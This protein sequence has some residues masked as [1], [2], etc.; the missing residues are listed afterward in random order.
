MKG[1]TGIIVALLLGLL[2]AS[3]NWVYLDN[4]TRQVKTV[5]F[6]GVRN[7]AKIR[8]GDTLQESFLEEVRIPEM[9]VGNLKTFVYLWQELETVKGIRAIRAYQGAE[10]LRR[11][12]YV[13]PPPELKLGKGQLL[14]WVPVDGRAF[15]PDLVNPGDQVTFLVPTVR[16]AVP[17]APTPAPPPGQPVDPADPT[18]Q[19]IPT[20]PPAANV[21]LIGPFTIAS[22]GSRLGS[23]E[24]SRAMMGR[25]VSD[26]EL[27]VYV[28]NE[29]T[30]GAPRLETKTTRLLEMSRRVGNQGIGI[31][32]H[33]RETP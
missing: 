12:D 30:E 16:S 3:L 2:G 1:A 31:I 24:V 15:V 7:D 4:K 14:I 28:K 20:A 11:E 6:I 25:S 21:E 9:N 5:S 33:P 18:G 17:G 19:P 23:A 22:V 8:P 32:L 13:T 29:G 10:L 27:G 26:F